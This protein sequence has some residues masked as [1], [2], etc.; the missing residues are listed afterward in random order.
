LYP[1]WAKVA[2]AFLLLSLLVASLPADD[3]LG[4][5]RVTA[6]CP[7]RLCCGP[8]AKGVTADGTVLHPRSR[9]VAAPASIPFGTVLAIP[10]YGS[11]PVADRGR[12]IKE[13]RLD[14]FFWTHQEALN[15]GVRYLPVR[16]VAP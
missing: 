2:V 10:G 9:L 12:A 13:G 1:S 16:R 11:V 14:V 4:L 8:N 15:W 3:S 7:C 5:Y 6:Y